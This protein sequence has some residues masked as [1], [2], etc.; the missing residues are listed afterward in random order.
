MGE[1][2][3]ELL[4]LIA[5]D[6]VCF[7]SALWLTLLV[8]YAALP[9]EELLK[10]HLGPFLILTG[11]W[12]GTFY[13]AGLYDKHTVLL[14]KFLFKRILHTQITNIIL[15]ALLFLIIPFGIA[16]K[17]NL[18]IYLCVSIVL[19]ALWRLRL[20]NYFSP[21]N[22][23]KA[24]LIAD[25]QEAIELVDEINNNTRYNYSFARLINEQAASHTPQFEEKLLELIHAENIEIIVANPNGQHIERILPSLFDLSF[26]QFEFTFL[27]FHKVYEDTFDRVPLSA[28]RYEWFIFNVSQTKSM[29]YEFV[30]RVIDI[31]GALLLLIPCLFIFP[32]VA[33]LIKLQDGGAIFYKTQRVGQFNHP[34][35]ILKFRSMT[36]MDDGHTTVNTKHTVTPLGKILRTT[37]IDELPQLLSV[38]RGDQ[39]FI[40]PRPEFPARAAVYAS[41]IPY[42]NARHFIKPGLS[43]WAQINESNVPRGDVDVALTKS[44]LSYDLFYLKNQSFALDMQ[45]ALKTIA[46]LL[47]RTGT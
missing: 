33:I 35:D 5:G 2:T 24:I 30:R 17:T 28:L 14:K 10:S 3:R 15:A 40:G 16:P 25:G 21:K 31:I 4:I 34:I 36:G 26:L 13:I 18:V 6:A 32:V 38:L 11:V 1:R 20:F 46:T 47:M 29:L 7:V 43:G 9:S 41:E 45:I 44:K 27:D 39:S 8:R 37:R 22:K 23:Q 42:Y 12:I 19:V